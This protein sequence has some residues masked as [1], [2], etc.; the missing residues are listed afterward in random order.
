MVSMV[1]A[2]ILHQYLL[3]AHM[4]GRILDVWRRL[5]AGEKDFFVPHDLEVSAP[6]LNHACQ[7]A[8]RWRGASGARR[9]VVLHDFHVNEENPD[10]A[11]TVTP[12][13]DNGDGDNSITVVPEPKKRW[14]RKKV[15]NTKLPCTTH[16]AI[17]DVSVNGKKSLHRQFLRIFDGTILEVFGEAGREVGWQLTSSL[18]ALMNE[19]AGGH[20]SANVTK[21]EEGIFGG[22]FS[23]APAPVA[24]GLL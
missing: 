19:E 2:L 16:V 1:T 10:E 5:N 20:G 11:A 3:H 14:F 15:F 7:R 8:R 24:S 17:Y 13:S 9:E 18:N 4:N 12:R 21:K 22:M 6:E 23:A